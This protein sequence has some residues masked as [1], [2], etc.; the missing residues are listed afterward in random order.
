MQQHPEPDFHKP[1]PVN[2]EEQSQGGHSLLSTRQVVHG[3]EALAGSHAV[4]V[5]PIQVGLLRVLRTQETLST[6][7]SG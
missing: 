5:N 4:V 3:P 7:V 6:L 2:G 1:P